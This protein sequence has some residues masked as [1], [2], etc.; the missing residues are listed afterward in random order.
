[1]ILTA[2]PIRLLS[3]GD[4]QLAE[5]LVAEAFRLGSGCRSPLRPQRG[6]HEV[7]LVHARLPIADSTPAA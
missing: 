4:R 3:V 1:V 7:G 6:P 5:D 2:G